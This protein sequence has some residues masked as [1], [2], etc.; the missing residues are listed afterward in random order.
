M[1]CCGQQRQDNQRQARTGHER[2]RMTPSKSPAIALPDAYFQYLGERALTVIGPVS[3]NQY[4]FD[5]Q[6]AVVPVDARDRRAVGAVN[7]LKR[8]G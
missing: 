5:Y 8:V 7:L 4:R 2:A 1:G 3:G 6:G